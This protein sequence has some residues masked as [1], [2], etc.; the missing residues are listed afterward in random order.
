MTTHVIILCPPTFSQGSSPA[1]GCMLSM[2]CDYRIMAD[3]ARYSIGLNE[4]QLGII[5]PFWSESINMGSVVVFTKDHR[6]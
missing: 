6:I 2:T 1:A 5:A 3:N 4:T